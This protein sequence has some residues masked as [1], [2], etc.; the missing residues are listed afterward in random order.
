MSVANQTYYLL[1]E[2]YPLQ[3]ILLWADKAKTN[4]KWQR[5]IVESIIKLLV[6]GE[7]AHLLQSVWRECKEEVDH[8]RDVF[9][10][11]AIQHVEMSF[12][13]K[14]WHF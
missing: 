2:E 1:R 11:D 12:R 13:E 14:F 3:S 8:L 9:G 7:V 4:N 5:N 10:V 6:R